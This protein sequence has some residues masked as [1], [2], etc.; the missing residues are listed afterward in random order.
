MF[1]KIHKTSSLPTQPV[2]VWDGKCGFCKFWKTRWQA[3]SPTTIRFCTFQDCAEEFPDIP[4]KEF[5]KASRLIEPDGKVYSGPDSAYRILWHQ[6]DQKWHNWYFSY[7]WF[8]KISNLGYNHIAKNRHFY[9]RLTKFLVG[10]DPL[11]FKF[12]WLFYLGILVLII[13]LL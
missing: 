8:R 7:S 11:N 10:K 5:K 13:I 6:G 9:F 1:G 4:L 2:L 3:H 12:Y